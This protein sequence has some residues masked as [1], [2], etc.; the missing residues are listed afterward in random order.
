MTL[1]FPL[2]LIGLIGI[3]VLILIYIIK[4]RYTEQIIASTYLWTLSEKFL[5]RKVPISKIAGLISLLLQILIVALVS[6]AI[7]HPMIVV[8]NSAN[9]Y[10]FVIDG[11]GSMNIVQNGSTRFDIAKNKICDIIEKSQNGSDYTLIYSGSS[12]DF[13]FEAV[14]DKKTAK[15]VVSELSV[16]YVSM[17]SEYALAAA[18]NYFDDNPSVLTYLLTDKSYAD[19]ENIRII[20]V[21]KEVE[22]YAISNVAYE[23]SGSKLK[24]T[25]TVTSYVSQETLMLEIYFDG[26]EEAYDSQIITT[27]KDGCDFEFLCNVTSFGYFKVVIADKDA[28]ALDNEVIIY[29]VEYQNVSDILLVSKSPFFIRAALASAGINKVEFI[30]PDEYD[31]QSGYGLYVFDSFM[32]KTLPDDGAVWFFNPDTTLAGTNFSYQSRKEDILTA[33][34]STSTT[35]TVKRLLTGIV[36]PEDK[37]ANNTFQVKGYV[38]CRLNGNFTTLATCDNNPVL[39]VGSNSYG[40]REAVFCF[41]IHDSAPFA[42]LGVL[43][44]LVKNLIDY[45]FPTVI[46]DTCYT[47]GDVIQV[48]MIAGCTNIRIETPNGK[49][50]YPD[51]SVAISEYKLTEVGVY[52]IVLVMKDKSERVLNIFSELPEEE[53]K[54]VSLG[55]SFIITGTAE[56]NKSDGYIEILLYIFIALAVLAVADYGLYCYEQYQLR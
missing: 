11:S 54:P 21:S 56:K 51:A 24:V 5:K 3:P 32:P 28:L 14:T 1:L 35:T 8:A 41:D 44:T 6:L 4:N 13:V 7:S 20:D 39:F 45:S 19:Y 53:R 16:E 55:D 46:S 15:Q 47:C 9:S 31:D 50:A 10:C 33:K 37:T 36:D 34:F 2:G 49:T 25:G 42:L 23:L 22:N 17:Q 26:E 12:T 52:K 18:Q 27:S 30:T 43:P 40:N 38:K 48:N 29:D